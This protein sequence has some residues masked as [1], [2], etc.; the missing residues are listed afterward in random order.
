VRK[1]T[2]QAEDCLIEMKQRATGIGVIVE[3]R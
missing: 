1:E 3:Q 2:L